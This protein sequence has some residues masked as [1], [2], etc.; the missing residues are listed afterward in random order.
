MLNSFRRLLARFSFDVGCVPVDDGG[1][2]VDMMRENST[3]GSLTVVTPSHQFPS[4][5]ILPVSRRLELLDYAS[6]ANGWVFEDDYDGELRLRGVPVP[7]VLCLDP[8]HVFYAG[9]F[10]KTLYPALRLGYLIV[11]EREVDPFAAMIRAHAEWPETLASGALAAF[12]GEGAYE[13]HLRALRKLYARR[14]AAL[15]ESVARHFGDA[16]AVKGSEAGCHCR[17]SPNF[18]Q[19]PRAMPSRTGSPRAALRRV[20]R[21]LALANGVAVAEV[22]HYLSARPFAARGRTVRDNDDSPFHDDLLLGYGNLDEATID[23]GI[24]TL[25]RART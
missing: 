18:P 4:G 15:T 8:A 10:N 9:T 17:L 21:E 16:Y 3:R 24:E 11:P 2:R 25:A 23:R 12:I 5:V 14:R 13:R 19:S 1:L 20:D 7:P 22:A 6:S